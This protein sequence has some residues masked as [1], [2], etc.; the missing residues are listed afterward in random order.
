MSSFRSF[1]VSSWCQSRHMMK[2][3]ERCC[4]RNDK[5]NKHNYKILYIC[6]SLM[7]RDVMKELYLMRQLNCSSWDCLIWHWIDE[8]RKSNV[9][10]EKKKIY[11]WNFQWI[12]KSSNRMRLQETDKI[13]DLVKAQLK[14]K[15]LLIA[16]EFLFSKQDILLFLLNSWIICM[17]ELSFL[18]FFIEEVYLSSNKHV[19]LTEHL[20]D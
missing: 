5:L 7:T 11:S 9:I 20:W 15:F 4:L 6:S 10:S 1:S 18:H 8:I 14:K 19:S 12:V 16:D 17:I 13:K 2:N 3:R